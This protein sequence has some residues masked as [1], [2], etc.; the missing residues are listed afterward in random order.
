[1]SRWQYPTLVVGAI[2]LIGAVVGFCCR[3]A[4]W[5]AL[6]TV[7]LGLVAGIY[8]TREFAM[9]SNSESLISPYVP[10]RVRPAEFDRAFPPGT[11][12]PDVIRLLNKDFAARA[13]A[14]AAHP[15]R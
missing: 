13:A 8:A 11:R 6:A 7:L 5:V 12:T 4:R 9:N 10:W 14:R 2:A 1:M 15:A 3:N